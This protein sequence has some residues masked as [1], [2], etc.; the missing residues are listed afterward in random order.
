MARNVAK[1]LP[2]MPEGF[3]LIDV[4]GDKACVRF[5]GGAETGEMSLGDCQAVAERRAARL[6]ANTPAAKERRRK[7]A[8]DPRRA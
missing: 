8:T 7:E 1:A 5:P 3:E 2:E 6:A 4:K